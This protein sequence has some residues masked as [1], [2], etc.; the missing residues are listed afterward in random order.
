MF[1]RPCFEIS[2]KL[3]LH[4]RSRIKIRAVNIEV[5]KKVTD[6]DLLEPGTAIQLF[7]PSIRLRLQVDR[8]PDPDVLRL[9]EQNL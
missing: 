1:V 7:H 4:R 8:P 3:D 6:L 9:L 2:Y 5:I